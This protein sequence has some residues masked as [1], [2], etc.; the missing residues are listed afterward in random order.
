[1]AATSCNPTKYV[2]S[3]ELLLS[4]NNLVVEKSKEPMPAPLNS[5]DMKPYIRQQPNK[6]I[7]GSRFHLGLYNL[8]NIE[9]E[10]WPHGWLR[11]IG[12]EPVVFDPIATERSRDQLAGYLASKG[13]FN[14]IV[15]DTIEVKKQEAEV[16]Y[17]VIPGRPYIIANISYDIQDTTFYS[18]VIM[19]T[20]NCLFER[21]MAYD[22]DLLRAERQRL[23]RYIRD[24]GY[25]S[26][27]AEDIFF[28]V[29]SSLMNHQVS[30]Q[31]VVTKKSILDSQGG[32]TTR[33]HIRH[34]IRDVYVFPEFEPREALTGG[35]EY[36]LTFDTTY[37][38]GI[39]F[40]S[41]PG[42][43][44]VKHEVIKQS[45]YISPGSPFSITNTDQTQAHLAALKNHRL[46]NVNFI[47]PGIPG[48]RGLNEGLLDCMI[49]LT[50]MPRQSFTVEF[51][52]TNAGGN[53]G[54]AVN[55]IYQNKSLF[56]GAENFSLKL[57]GAYEALTEDVGA[58][59]SSQE[60]G[61]E[62][63]LRLPKFLMPFPAK[64]NFI[65][66][67]DPK[68]VILAG[69]NYQK[70][71]VYT[72]TIANLT[73]GYS[74]KGNR[75]ITNTVNPLVINAVDIKNMDPDFQAKVDTTSYLAYSYRP[76]M[77]VGGNYS[78]VFN[79]QILQNSIDY[80]Y[81]RIG[82]NLAGNL[83]SAAYKL[84]GA[85]KTDDGYLLAGQPFAQFVKLEADASYHYKINE[86]STVVYRA[87]TGL[88]LSYGNSRVMPFE[89]QYFGGGANDL[90]AWTVKTLGPGSYDP[91]IESDTTFLYQIAD[92]K[93]E[94]NFEYRFKLF[95]IM[96][97]ATF[98]DVGNIWTLREDKD[99]PGGQFQFN[100]FLDD[101]AVGTGLGLR[102]DI[103]FVMLRA[104]LGLKLRDPKISDGSKWIPL[105]RPYS[106]RDDVA[107]V[108]GIGYPF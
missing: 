25:Y 3:D 84:A 88:G 100:R 47:D 28:R 17:K 95:W 46:I 19:D 94:A 7:F 55:F 91:D 61:I 10:K 92:I 102:F 71:P 37:F 51:E 67:H 73:L 56:R 101:L 74:W 6:R 69:Y 98:I 24:I 48:G 78:L 65:R 15:E 83:L 97:G 104:D 89:E 60:F 87:F 59:K 18:L 70:M 41:P 43:S 66:K 9:K 76:V 54:G 5:S 105:T 106:F 31:Y 2:P 35:E 58:L 36:A 39:H 79:N 63:A 57:K 14:A 21:G 53:L 12:E 107:I 27:S 75:Y 64:E 4:R 1:L 103:K 86:A 81:L 23:E 11:R 20:V 34:R 93:L 72:R 8:S 40:V 45:L 90:R 32:L 33:N 96:E 30:V 77:I 80:W 68:T 50:P 49:Q 22:V 44:P 52:G 108:V 85:N 16:S 26:F 82:F 99:R 13:Y 62:T 29:D 38:E 42:K